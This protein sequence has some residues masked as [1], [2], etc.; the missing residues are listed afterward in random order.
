MAKGSSRAERLTCGAAAPAIVAV[1]TAPSPA[2]TMYELPTWAKFE[3]G[4]HP[5]FWE[6]SSGNSPAAGEG[7]TI[8]FIPSA[9][10][11]TPNDEFGIGFNG[12]FNSPIMCSGE[13]R[14]MTKRE[15]G[16]EC[17]P[18]YIIKINVPLHATLIEFSF[19]DAVAWDGPYALKLEVLD[20]FKGR[21]PGF[22][23]DGLTAELAFEGACDSAIFPEAPFVQDRCLMP[24]GI[25]HEE[26]LACALDINP[27]CTDPESPF[28]DPFATHDDGSCPID[29]PAAPSKE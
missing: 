5:V 28:F 21:P 16:P 12:G 13:P 4:H 9:T 7:L 23:A 11:L 3:M 18:F 22:F 24:G 19:T 27:G 25:V 1:A 10:K 6:T 14:L 20:K 2:A 29:L 8:W 26:G 17:A 15:R